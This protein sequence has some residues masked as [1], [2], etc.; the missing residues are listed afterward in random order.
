MRRTRVSEG[1]IVLD[2]VAEPLTG[3]AFAPFGEVITPPTTER[4]RYFNEALGD[5]RT[6]AELRCWISRIAPTQNLPLLCEV[7]ERHPC[8]TQTFLPMSVSRFV[9]VVAGAGP[10]GDP[11]VHDLKAFI[12]S[13]RHGVTYRANV[14]HHGMVVLDEPALFVVIN[15]KDDGPLDEKFVRLTEAATIRLPTIA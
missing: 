2:L 14:W 4:R 6:S 5:S 10:D 1:G 11:D 15:W 12:G 3:E 9:I 8:G 7:M 13:S